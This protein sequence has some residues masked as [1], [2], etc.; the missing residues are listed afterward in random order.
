MN[1]GGSTT[2]PRNRSVYY[3]V[4]Y[5]ILKGWNFLRRYARQPSYVLTYIW[6]VWQPNYR[7]QILFLND[8]EFLEQAKTKSTIR[9]GDGEF[10]L[11]L[12]T[13]DIIVQKFDPAL[14]N[15]FYTLAREYST[16]SPYLLALPP[17][18]TI[19][20]HLLEKHDFHYLWMPGKILFRLFFNRK[21]AY[22]DAIFF[23]RK[24]AVEKFLSAVSAGRHI[25]F[26]TNR[27]N[28]EKLKVKEKHLVSNA[29]KVSYVQTPDTNTFGV[30]NQILESI[31]QLIGQKTIPA[32]II[33]ACG[34]AGK[35]LA[36]TLATSNEA[37]AH[38]VGSG[39][40]F[41]F[42]TE[43]H[44]PQI[45]WKEF[46]GLYEERRDAEFNYSSLTNRYVQ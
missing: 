37:V 23:Y 6:H 15:L 8:T 24:G 29:T 44:E 46:G 25:I 19:E 34:P 41:L 26:V 17:Y 3:R 31:R 10:T 28:I 30:R 45:K 9:L 32:T 5:Y 27:T 43:D 36:H 1:L 11:M 21:V 7:E 13:R 33:F 12:G 14:R 22:S 39:I 20:N 2:T 38:D 42:D 4:I 18:L 16:Q 40:A 35:V